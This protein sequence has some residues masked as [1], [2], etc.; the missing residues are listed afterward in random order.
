MVDHRYL[1]AMRIPLRSGRYFVARD[2]AETE[3][4]IIINETMA[5]GLCRV[6]TRSDMSSVSVNQ[7][8]GVVGVV[9]DVRHAT[10]EERSSP[11]MYLNFRQMSDW[12]AIDVVVR[13]T[14]PLPAWL[15]MYAQR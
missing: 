6:K 3:N 15:G 4:V 9:S 7:N 10:L 11:E 5:R 12:F 14:R 2:T 1:Q 8:G 13:S